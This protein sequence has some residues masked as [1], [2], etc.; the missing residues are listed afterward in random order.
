PMVPAFYNLPI[1]DSRDRYSGKFNLAVRGGDTQL[2]AFVGHGP[3]PAQRDAIVC[4]KYVFYGYLHIRECAADA[5]YKWHEVLW[6]TKHFSLLTLASR[7]AIFGKEFMNGFH[8]PFIP[9]FLKP[10]PRQSDIIFY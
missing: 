4:A 1:P 2:I 7:H 10:A 8:A 3:R 5:L 9:H 6:S